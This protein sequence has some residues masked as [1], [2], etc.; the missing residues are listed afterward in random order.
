MKLE[1]ITITKVSHLD[2]LWKRDWG[3]LGNGPMVEHCTAIVQVRFESR[4]RPNSSGLSPLLSSSVH[5]CKNHLRWN[6][7]NPPFTY[8]NF[9][10]CQVTFLL[11]L[12]S[13]LEKFLNLVSF[14]YFSL[15]EHSETNRMTAQNLAIV[16]GPNLMW[17]RY[18]SGDIA[19]N[20][21]HQN[22]IIEFLLL[23]YDHVFK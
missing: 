1:L 12:A 3:E 21:V 2:S 14:C 16:W 9:I 6:C 7:F 10:Y 17:P 18:D 19:I 5:I 22:Q 15:M 11:L 13:S 23:E 20:M 8:N 4:S